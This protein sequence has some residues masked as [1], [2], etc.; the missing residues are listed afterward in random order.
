MYLLIGAAAVFAFLVWVGR[1][2]RLGKLKAGPWIRQK[3]ALIAILA[4]IVAMAGVVCVARGQYILASIL[5]TIAFGM[6]GGARYRGQT[7]PS[8][9]GTHSLAEIEAYRALGIPAGSDRKTILKA[10]KARMKDAH[11]D[12]G[13]SDARAAKLNAARDVLLKR[14]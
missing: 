13:G 8:T 6:A 10:W 4:V 14:K 1:Q 2:S 3:R 7:Q 5:V 12:Q 11:P 9:D